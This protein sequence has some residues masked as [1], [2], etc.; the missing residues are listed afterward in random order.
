MVLSTYNPFMDVPNDTRR[1][2]A[3]RPR[4]ALVIATAVA[5]LTPNTSAPALEPGPAALAKRSGELNVL[6]VTIDT[7]RADRLGCYGY[8]R[9]HTPVIDSLAA[10]GVRFENAYSHHPV[11]LPS[12][13]TLFTG[14]HAAH[15]GV[16]D[17]GLFRLADE[18]VTVAETLKGAGFSTGA[19]ISSF[20]LNSQYGLDQG[21]DMYDDSLSVGRKQDLGGF[22][23]MTA[24][25]VS[26]RA[27]EWIEQH[28]Q[29]RWFL[30][31]HYYDP[32][33]D[34]EPP[35]AYMRAGTKPY[36]GEIAYV[37]AELGRLMAELEKRGLTER[38]L[39]IITSDHG[40]SLGEHEEL[41]H[42]LFL[43]EATM[44]V[45]LIVSLPGAIPAGRVAK[46]TVSLVDVA[47]TLLSVLDLTTPERAQGR[48]LMP[49]LFSDPAEWTETP[50]IMETMT[51]WHQYGFS[52][53]SAMV[54][55]NF[56]FIESPRPE[57]YDLTADPHELTNIIDQNRSRARSMAK[58][59]RELHALYS[60]SSIEGGSRVEMDDRA[61]D[62]L[63]SLGYVF[64]GPSSDEGFGDAPDV[65][66]KIQIMKAIKMAS[67]L[68]AAGREKEA[69]STLENVLE[70]SPDTR[71]VLN[72]LGTWYA[73]K[74]DFGNGE[75]YFK[76]LLR[77]DPDYIEAYNKPWS[78]LRQCLSL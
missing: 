30:W 49:L 72:R 62:R 55:G 35:P 19:V 1:V 11:T 75:R 76:R 63:K 48:S 50:V 74:K 18:A 8:T 25:G 17:N 31:L 46:Q 39:T 52:P 5:V 57:L 58:Q 13:V 47:P 28:A 37:D 38:T 40:E 26:D 70:S 71:L 59:R 77:L 51:P 61:R 7:L 60:E 20:V 14:T 12:H 43:Y 21:F 78:A 36:D 27:L 53:T 10:S 34:F 69:F 56:K 41:A 45:P 23:E 16:D 66:D 44:R 9:A 42:G 33:G 68:R 6:F 67:E 4:I 24:T 64:A 22:E 15:H 73:L 3:Q 29:E 54:Q 32:H 65:K 2:A